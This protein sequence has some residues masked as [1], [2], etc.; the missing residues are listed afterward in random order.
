MPKF[1]K[2][3][4][5]DIVAEQWT[6][7]NIQEIVDFAGND[8]SF[9]YSEGT[10]ILTI[11]TLEGDMKASINDYI[12]KGLKGEFYP[13]KPDVFEKKYEYAPPEMSLGTLYEMNQQLSAQ[14]PLISREEYRKKIKKILSFIQNHE[15]K[16]FMLLNNENCDYTLFNIQSKDDISIYKN[17]KNDFKECL[18]NRGGIVSIEKTKDDIAFEIW[19]RTEEGDKVYYFFPYDNGVLE[20][21]VVN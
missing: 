8:A 4:P 11:S 7:E 2:T 14:E 10:P 1:Y 20:Y 3:K 15:Q 12:I 13:C 21:K 6:G 16:Y 17:L 19:L 5:C 18:I 9:D